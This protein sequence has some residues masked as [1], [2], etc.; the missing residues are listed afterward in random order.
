MFRTERD[1]FEFVLHSRWPEA[2][3][4]S[5]P[6]CGPTRF[7][8]REDR[9]A[10]ACA[11]CKRYQSATSGTVMH[12]SRLPLS[13]WLLSA[14]LLTTDKRGVSA[15]QL[16]RQLGTSYA[17]AYMVLQRLR[18]AMVHPDRRRLHGRIEV[19]ETFVGGVRHG[20]R[21][22]EMRPG[23]EGKFVV[24]G[25]VEVRSGLGGDLE[26][27]RRPG[28][29]RLRHVAD[30]RASTLL[31][32]VADTATPGSKIVTDGNPS[33]RGVVDLG[34]LHGIESTAL[35]TPQKEVL[36]RA[37]LAF[38][39]LKTWL[40]GT[41]HGRVEGKHLQGYLN[42]FCFRFN[43]RD[44]LPA[45][46]Q[47]V[48]GI[49]PLVRGPTYAGLHANGPERFLHVREPEPPFGRAQVGVRVRSAG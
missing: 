38:S 48:L 17:T 21:G 20:R 2:G 46:F 9:L 32:F 26:A 19:D 23:K 34:Y 7:H 33:Y 4:G 44:D 11:S 39:N 35:G 3:G 41:F 14:W 22:R 42:E 28:R 37:H 5:C 18:A 27:F 1:C 8:P 6:R 36:T 24:L 10:L 16:Q 13:A 12:R 49:A 25:A 15:K 43:R 31:D 40:A 30:N 45:A 47:T 29:I